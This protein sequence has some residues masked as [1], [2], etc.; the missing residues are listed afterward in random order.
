MLEF[1]IRL[2]KALLGRN[3][4]IPVPKTIGELIQYPHEIFPE[5]VEWESGDRIDHHYNISFQG[6]LTYDKTT[7]DGF[8]LLHKYR[9]IKQVKIEKIKSS[10]TNKS[11][12]RRKIENK[13]NHDSYS[14]FLDDFQR[15]YKKIS[16]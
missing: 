1:L 8:V 2:F 12:K 14:T 13:Y 16:Q 6:M 4:P 15:E 3:I 11:L 5:I 9:D 10:Y 7:E